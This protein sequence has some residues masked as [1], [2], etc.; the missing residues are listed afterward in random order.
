MTGLLSTSDGLFYGHGWGFLGAQT[1]GILAIDI[2]AAVCG[3]VLFYAIKKIHG[4]RVE[5]RVEEEG[6]DVYEHGENCYN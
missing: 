6:L 2:W 1:F 5:S 4:L 3:F